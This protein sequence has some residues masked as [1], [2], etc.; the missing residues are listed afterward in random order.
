MLT[1]HAVPTDATLP[2]PSESPA[3]GSDYLAQL[4]RH[5]GLDYVALNPGASFRGLHDSLV[6]HLGDR[7]PKMLTV[8]HEEHAVAIAH[9][10]AKVAG[11]PM[12][13]I[14]HANV[15]L[16]HGS[17]AIFDAFCDRV[18]VLLFGATGPVDAAV[19]RPWIDWIHTAKDQGALVRS[20]VK[21]DAQ[22]ASLGAARDDVLRAARI[23]TTAPQGPTYVCFDTGLQEAAI[24]DASV[25]PA[26]PP[27]ARYRAPAPSVANATTVAQVTERLQSATRPVLL[28]G[29]VSRDVGDWARRIELAERLGA[30]VLTDFKVAAAFPTDHPRHPVAPSFFLT[31]EAQ[32]VLREADAIVGFDWVDLGGTLKNV[33]PDGRVRAFVAHVSMDQVLHNG[34]GM[35]HQAVVPCD[36]Y[37]LSDPD[38]FV[39]QLLEG[40]AP[41]SAGHAAVAPSAKTNPAQAEPAADREDG[42]AM[43]TFAGQV[44]IQL[45]ANR[46]ATLIR[47]NLGW[48]GG[49]WPLRDPLDYLGYDGGGG[50]GSGPGMAVGGALAL[51]GTGRLPV[52]VLGDG[53]FLMGGT[54]LW[55]AVRYGI[56]LL[57]IVANNRSFFNDE[58]HQE[59]V[60][61][62]RGRPVENK[63]IGQRM[64]SPDIDLAGFARAQGARAWGPVAGSADL[65]GVLEEAIAAVRA[66]AVAVVDVR[67]CREY[68]SAM[69]HGLTRGE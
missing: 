48:P 4:L 22:P 1:T 51:R 32:Q 25:L 52:A 24:G 14:L 38:A 27:M 18:P 15:G 11:K 69:T 64:E 21:W 57:V 35:E 60:A 19:R 20:F 39:G 34:F 12:G 17:M 30:T 61:V 47:A 63:A 42:I 53:D 46:P 16:M 33:W 50:I 40:L 44:A 23:A 7:G 29:R 8:L 65:S 66:G 37:S 54:A 26:L 41:R 13:A 28:F 68:T 59:K 55:T 62:V 5:V 3:W 43:S 45:E 6:N 10:Y 56:P 31:A 9:G 58:V 49:A 67:V 36:A 2:A